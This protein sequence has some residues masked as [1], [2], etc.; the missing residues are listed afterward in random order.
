MHAVVA[1]PPLRYLHFTLSFLH[2]TGKY[3]T[4]G[5]V[6]ILREGV[7]SYA[8]SFSGKRTQVYRGLERGLVCENSFGGK[9]T[10]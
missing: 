10:F 8:V 6:G 5:V 9:L 7:H 4:T 1:P 2:C 3:Y